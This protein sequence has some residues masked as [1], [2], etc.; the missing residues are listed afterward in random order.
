ML[1]YL[2][3]VVDDRLVMM[4]FNDDLFMY[5][6]FFMDTFVTIPRQ[7][8]MIL[9]HYN[10]FNSNNFLLMSAV[11]MFHDMDFFMDHDFL[12]MR[13]CVMM[14]HDYFLIDN[15]F[16]M[17]TLVMRDWVMMLA[18]VIFLPNIMLFTETWVIRAFILVII[19]K[20]RTAFIKGFKARSSAFV[21]AF[22]TGLEASSSRRLNAVGE[23][24]YAAF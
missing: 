12:M 23:T 4:L 5:D 16:P 22:I 19:K 3:V 7:C 9:F 6:N 10:F 20:T 14:F 1:K 11:K 13:A 8:V 2:E 21:E 24:A 18:H 17:D 15:N